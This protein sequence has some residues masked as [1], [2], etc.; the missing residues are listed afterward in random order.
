MSRTVIR[1]AHVFDG[2]AFA[3]PQTVVIEGSHIGPERDPADGDEIIDGTGCTILPGLIDCHVHIADEAQLASCA[4]FGVTTV[5]D[6]GCVPSD[7]FRTLREAHGPT[8]WLGAGLPAFA[9]GSTHARLFRLAGVGGEQAVHDVEEAATF[10]RAR[11]QHDRVDYVKVIADVPGHDQ[12]VLDKICEEARRHGKMTVA[13][14]AHFEAFPRCLRAGFDIL[15]HV[16]LDKPLRQDMAESMAAQGMF[17]VPTLTMM[18]TFSQSW[19][20]WMLMRRTMNF[21]HSMRS[22]RTMREA[23]VPILAGTDSHNAGI[24]FNIP[25]GRSLHHEIELLVKAGL[26]P[27]EALRA[28]TSQAARCFSLDDRGRVKPGFRADLVLVQGNPLED[29]SVTRRIVRVW[30]GGQP[31]E[32]AAPTGNG[33]CVMM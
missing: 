31:V 1:N 33:A 9:E 29:I 14:A 2:D 12:A 8:S 27:V 23:G 20:M 11:A 7:K 6:M 26:S 18:E 3:G 24:L 28:A 30:S 4:S 5:C 25:A 16:P 17:A 15:T 19:V 21:D 22:V 32:P 10:V 13:H